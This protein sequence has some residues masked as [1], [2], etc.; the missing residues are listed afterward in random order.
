MPFLESLSLSIPKI[1]SAVW[2]NGSRFLW[3]VGVAGAAAAALLWVGAHYS[4]PKAQAW[5]DDYGLMLMVGSAVVA[6]F[7]VFKMQ[8]ERPKPDLFLI[9][10]EGQSL[11]HHAKHKD[12]SM[13]T[14]FSLR[15]QAT[16]RASIDLNLSKVRIL[17]PRIKRNQILPAHIATENPMN[18]TYS[19]DHVVPAK[20]RRGCIANLTVIG[21]VGGEGRRKPMQ[22]KIAVQDNI[23]RW[24]KLVFVDL[25]DPQFPRR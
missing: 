17:R 12:G 11:W 14:H 2:A 13:L 22:V 4:V 23:G 9:A 25:R 8:A 3:S 19:K 5:W 6:V 16:N 21:T 10:D 7:A 20:T 24:H 15:F 18:G 1:I